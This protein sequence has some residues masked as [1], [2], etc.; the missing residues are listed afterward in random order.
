MTK[1]VF[2]MLFC[3]LLITAMTVLSAGCANEAPEPAPTP[4]PAPTPAPATEIDPVN[5]KF[6]VHTIQS[7]EQMEASFAFVEEVKERSGG[8]ITFDY[9]GGNEVIPQ[10]EQADAVRTG[11]V[12][13]GWF[14]ATYAKGIVAETAALLVISQNGQER[15]ESGINDLLNEILA[16]K[17]L[18]YFMP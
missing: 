5:F 11:V 9:L 18:Y 1:K 7:E 14:P 2:F 4:T 17:N 6:V 15:R 3:I 16:P 13:A 8:K 12:D 10:F